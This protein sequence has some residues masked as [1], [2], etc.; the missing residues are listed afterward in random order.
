[1]PSHTF[2]RDGA[3]NPSTPPIAWIAIPLRLHAIGTCQISPV[4]LLV[5]PCKVVAGA[6][7]RS[8][9]PATRRRAIT[10][11]DRLCRKLRPRQPVLDHHIAEPGPGGLLPLKM[12]PLPV[13]MGHP[14]GGIKDGAKPPQWVLQAFSFLTCRRQSR[15]IG[16]KAA[17]C[18]QFSRLTTL[19]E[20]SKQTFIT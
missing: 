11:S 3:L 8:S 18:R 4:R 6:S 16:E 7:N 9:S 1:M 13:G 5:R 10:R 15:P 20:Q 17:L 12:A 2:Q 14:H 19:F